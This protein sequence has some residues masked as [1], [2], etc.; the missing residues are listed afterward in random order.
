MF[1][2][3]FLEKPGEGTRYIVSKYTTELVETIFKD[4]NDFV[5]KPH[6]KEKSLC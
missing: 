1:K 3:D 5:L 4:I 2:T 6:L